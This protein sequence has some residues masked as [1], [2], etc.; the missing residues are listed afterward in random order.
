MA[1]EGRTATASWGEGQSRGRFGGA[2][3][4]WVRKAVLWWE[5]G[6]SYAQMSPSERT[7]VPFVSISH[8]GI[9]FLDFIFYF[10]RP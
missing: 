9:P 6:T 7:R 4:L 3:E 8:S 10:V 2:V 1:G 5:V